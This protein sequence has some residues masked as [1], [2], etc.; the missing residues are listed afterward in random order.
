MAVL[1]IL[2]ITLAAVVTLV[3][4]V[5]RPKARRLKLSGEARWTRLLTRGTRPCG[6]LR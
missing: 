3:V 6:W 1:L 2:V 5:R 4:L